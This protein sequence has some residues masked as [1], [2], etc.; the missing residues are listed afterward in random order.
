MEFNPKV[1]GE[2]VHIQMQTGMKKYATE[3]F[4]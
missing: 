4:T 2:K 3:K 1:Y